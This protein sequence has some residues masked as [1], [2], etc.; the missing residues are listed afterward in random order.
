[1]NPVNDFLG[2]FVCSALRPLIDG[3][4]LAVTYGGVECGRYLSGHP[5]VHSIHLTGAWQTHDAIVWGSN[6]KKASADGSNLRCE[7]MR[8]F[9]CMRDWS[10]SI[11]C[12]WVGGGGNMSN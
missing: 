8:A 3:G 7:G 10:H 1:M 4:F 12:V 11:V 9:L 6:G 5:L 2:P